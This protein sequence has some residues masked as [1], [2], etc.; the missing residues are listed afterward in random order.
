MNAEA[1]A[2][3][4]DLERASWGRGSGAARSVSAGP[5]A[6]VPLGTDVAGPAARHTGAS[7]AESVKVAAVGTTL[8]FAF[9]WSADT[10]GRQI[11]A[12]LDF[13]GFPGDEIAAGRW[14]LEYVEQHVHH[15]QS[16]FPDELVSVSDGVALLRVRRQPDR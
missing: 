16:W 12:L 5:G 4:A 13:D 1:V 15:D 10:Q 9:R 6:Y 8:V 14:L 7:R 11:V 3:L 2:R